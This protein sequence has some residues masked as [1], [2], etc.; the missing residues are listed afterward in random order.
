MKIHLVNPRLPL[1][2]TSNEYAA[3]MTL[4]KY[5][6]PPLG[7][8]TVAAMIPNRH[9]TSLLDENVSEIDWDVDCDVV[10]ITGMHLQAPR[11]R[12]IAAGFR[13]RGKQVVIGGPSAMSVPE[14][15]RDV[16][17]ILVIGE[18]EHI[19]PQCLADLERGAAQPLY[20]AETTVD[21]A[22]SPIP[23][24]DLVSPRDYL[25]IS[26]QTTRGC[27]FQCEFC[28]IITLYGR[29]VRTKPVEHV[30][31]EVE[32]IVALGWD[33]FFFVDD[34]FIGDPRYASELLAA[35]AH[36]RR[37]SPR[38]FFFTTQLTINLA[39]NKALMQLLHDAGCRSVFIGIETPRTSSLRET[40]KFQN[41]RKDLLADVERIQRSG[42]AV[43]SGIVVG[44]DHDDA[45]IFDEQVQFINDASIP[46]P[47]PS[48]LGALPG[49]PLH[50]RLAA[51]GRLLPDTEFT[52]NAF[53]TNLVPKQMTV[54]ELEAGYRRM[55]GALYA[56]ASFA[57]RVAGEL[58]RISGSVGRMSNYRWPVL[59]AGFAWV[60]AWF[61]A[62]IN[63][64]KLLEAYSRIVATVLRRPHLAEAALQRLVIYRHVC[65][66]VSMIEDRAKRG[67]QAPTIAG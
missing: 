6:N 21:L 15:Y 56:P 29:K 14:R 11:M 61:V 17:D 28:D 62:D 58:E 39:Q 40:L 55:V 27:P 34:N 59:I 13:E 10:G 19:W 37:R 18:A 5:S 9:V 23:R 1:S 57:R 46:L 38:P 51:D 7:L 44:F 65:R 50:S 67:Q 3:R 45:D 42:L 64:S 47:L 53:Y 2:F 41:V 36:F 16:A 24:F 63:R 30:I 22:A 49:T 66:F 32:R 48:I 8:L 60:L 43:Y 54:A 20:K 12:E 35:L 33:R 25:S 4:R 52:V 31:A 26:L